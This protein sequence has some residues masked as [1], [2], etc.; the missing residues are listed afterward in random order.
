MPSR[1]RRHAAAVT[2]PSRCI[3]S[4]YSVQMLY[5]LYM[6]CMLHIQYMHYAGCAQVRTFAHLHAMCD[7]ASQDEVTHG[8]QR[9]SHMHPRRPIGAR[10]RRAP[11]DAPAPRKGGDQP[12]TNFSR[13]RIEVFLEGATQVRTFAYLHAIYDMGPISG[14]PK[15]SYRSAGSAYVAIRGDKGVGHDFP[16]GYVWAP[17]VPPSKHID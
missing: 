17:G 7:M 12:G 16:N 9:A 4:K 3:C 11:Q 6:L 1:R 15:E 8:I 5:V 10:R 2:P 14:N 13:P